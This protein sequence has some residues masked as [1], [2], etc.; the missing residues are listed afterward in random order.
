[1]SYDIFKWSLDDDHDAFASGAEERDRLLP[2]NQFNGAQVSF[3]RRMQ[4]RPE[5]AL[6]RPRD[7]DNAIRQMLGFTRWLDQAIANMREGIDKGI[8]QPR[9]VIERIVGQTET[10]AKDDGTFFL[11]QLRHMP[12]NLGRE[13]RT[14][15]EAAYSEAVLGELVPAYRRL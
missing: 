5:S 14:R 12:A 1:L 2:L 15:I 6:E 10:F 4:W 9:A 7:Y 3:A 11:E 8:V 13:D